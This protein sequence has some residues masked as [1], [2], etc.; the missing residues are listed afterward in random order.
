[1]LSQRL[2][3]LKNLALVR[4]SSNIKFSIWVN[5]QLKDKI[6]MLFQNS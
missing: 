1:M 5:K 2:V 6:S 4:T 3:H